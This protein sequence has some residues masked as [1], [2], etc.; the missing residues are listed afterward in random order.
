M[1][2]VPAMTLKN[3]FCFTVTDDAVV[4]VQLKDRVPAVV[5]LMT[6]LRRYHVVAVLTC[7]LF[8]V[9]SVVIWTTSLWALSSAS[10]I[11]VTCMLTLEAVP[12]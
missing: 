1:A 5:V 4:D 8:V 11:V 7:M 3:E 2:P 10:I 6:P 9:P 12:V